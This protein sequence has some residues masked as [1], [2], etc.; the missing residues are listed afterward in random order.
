MWICRIHA[1]NGPTRHAIVNP[2]GFLQEPSSNCPWGLQD[3]KKWLVLQVLAA[4][5]AVE[6]AEEQAVAREAMAEVPMLPFQG[7]HQR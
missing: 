4:G 2:K 6:T 3:K 1:R 5:D 7:M